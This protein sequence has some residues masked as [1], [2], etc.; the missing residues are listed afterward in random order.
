MTLGLVVRRKLS[1]DAAQNLPDVV[2][3]REFGGVAGPV[4]ESVCDEDPA[5]L[6]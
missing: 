3:L 4:L 1:D 2:R 5:R 6:E